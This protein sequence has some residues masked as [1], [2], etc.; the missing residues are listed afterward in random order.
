MQRYLRIDDL[1]NIKIVRLFRKL[2]R[3]VNNNLFNYNA[4]TEY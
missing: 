3:I 2:E 1:E 4:F